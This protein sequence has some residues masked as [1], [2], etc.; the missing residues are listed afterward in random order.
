ML[1]EQKTIFDPMGSVDI[2]WHSGISLHLHV[3]GEEAWE[4][5]KPLKYMKL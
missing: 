3:A 5:R 2:Y 1:V 4:D